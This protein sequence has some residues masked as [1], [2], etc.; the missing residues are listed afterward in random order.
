M[1]GEQF[2]ALREWIDRRTRIML[3]IAEHPN[4]R[5]R[6]QREQEELQDLDREA[7][8]VLVDPDDKQIM[9]ELME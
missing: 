4:D 5:P 6:V 2:Y 9:R 1:T 8:I 7:R 3:S